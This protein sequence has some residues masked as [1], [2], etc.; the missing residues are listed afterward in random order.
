METEMVQD[1]KNV[2]IS[3]LPGPC[4]EDQIWLGDSKQKSKVS[5]VRLGYRNENRAK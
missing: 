4:L 3:N 5:S 2:K 1:N